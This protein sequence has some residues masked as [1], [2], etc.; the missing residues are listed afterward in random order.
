MVMNGLFPRQG[1][2]WPIRHR[3]WFLAFVG[4]CMLQMA[5]GGSNNSGSAGVPAGTYTIS[6]TGAAT[7]TQ[8]TAAVTLTVH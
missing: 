8:H 7:S 6:I 1:V 5:C 3:A 4:A 2:V